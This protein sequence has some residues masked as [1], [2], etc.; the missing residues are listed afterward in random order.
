MADD[1]TDEMVEAWQTCLY[2]LRDFQEEIAV[3]VNAYNSLK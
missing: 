3:T 1:V 2:G